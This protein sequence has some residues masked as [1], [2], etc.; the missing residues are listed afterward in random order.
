MAFLNFHVKLTPLLYDIDHM[1]Q[2]RTAGLATTNHA[3][4]CVI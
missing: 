1:V 2:L 4:L 3:P